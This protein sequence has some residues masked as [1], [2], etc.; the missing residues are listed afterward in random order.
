LGPMPRCL[1]KQ[2]RSMFRIDILVRSGCGSN[3]NRPKEKK[4]KGG[5]FL[6]ASL[7][8]IAGIHSEGKRG[9]PPKSTSKLLPCGEVTK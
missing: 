7:K 8:L 4:L 6:N 5:G 3:R 2:T 1:S 9:K